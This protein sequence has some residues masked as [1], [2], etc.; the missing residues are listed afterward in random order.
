MKTTNQLII[1]NLT[2]LNIEIVTTSF[3]GVNEVG[4]SNI[5]EA[6]SF[7]ETPEEDFEFLEV[8]NQNNDITKYVDLYYAGP[9][10]AAGATATVLPLIL[11][12]YARKLLNLGKYLPTNKRQIIYR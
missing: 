11:G 7:L 8:S 3:V 9:I 1:W 5:L 10:R 4:K 6:M 2:W 12:D